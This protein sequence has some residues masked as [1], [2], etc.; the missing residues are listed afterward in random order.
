M[1]K[2]LRHQSTP[3]EARRRA[4]VRRISSGKL[5]K[6]A[7]VGLENDIFQ[8]IE[9]AND[10]EDFRI[11]IVEVLS[12]RKPRRHV[13]VFNLDE[14]GFEYEIDGVVFNTTIHFKGKQYSAWIFKKGK[15]GN[16]GGS[17]DWTYRSAN[18]STVRKTQLR[19]IV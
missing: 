18:K 5:S 10:Y 13:I 16:N 12:R 9:T 15:F 14:K 19:E 11:G 17:K 7:A 6:N 1:T 8:V 4:F 2:C 3:T